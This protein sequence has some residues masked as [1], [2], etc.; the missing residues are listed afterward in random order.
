MS[1]KF[2][3]TKK[4][5]FTPKWETTEMNQITYHPYGT[6]IA[7]AGEFLTP[8]FLAISNHSFS[9]WANFFPK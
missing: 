2:K 8:L 6:M 5:N 4:V 1:V 9:S 3:N 7:R